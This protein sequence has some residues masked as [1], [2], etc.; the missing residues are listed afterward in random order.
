[1]GAEWSS[2]V[3]ADGCTDAEPG[4]FRRHC[5]NEGWLP[6]GAGPLNTVVSFSRGVKLQKTEKASCGCH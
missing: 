1:M 4:G 2:T 6:G 5:W 3:S